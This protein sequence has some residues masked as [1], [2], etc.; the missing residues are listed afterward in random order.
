MKN[1]LQVLVG[2]EVQIYPGDSNKKRG[3]LLEISEQGYLFKI[4]YYSGTDRNYE[5][6]KLHFIGKNNNIIIKEI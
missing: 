2:K 6:G 3:I 5:V 4:T 1:S